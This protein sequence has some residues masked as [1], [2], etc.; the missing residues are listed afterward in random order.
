M[1]GFSA[2]QQGLFFLE[3]F[4]FPYEAMAHSSPSPRNEESLAADTNSNHNSD[5]DNND[6]ND[7]KSKLP[8]HQ[9]SLSGSVVEEAS[10]DV[11]IWDWSTHVYNATSTLSEEEDERVD[12][13]LHKVDRKATIIVTLPTPAYMK[14]QQDDIPSPPRP[15][16]TPSRS[17]ETHHNQREQQRRVSL[18]TM[19]PAH[20]HPHR[21]VLEGGVWESASSSDDDEDEDGS[22]LDDDWHQFR[23]EWIDFNAAH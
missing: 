8:T 3:N 9:R 15:L 7:A 23:V 12:P 19:L 13:Y 21:S 2:W 14:E 5:D 16:P 17:S 4:S 6:D 11:R 10:L 20:H 1:Y 22:G 18:Q